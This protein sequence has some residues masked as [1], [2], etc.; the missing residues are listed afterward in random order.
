[1]VSLLLNYLIATNIR[2][3]KEKKEEVEEMIQKKDKKDK[4][5]LDSR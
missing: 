3:K 5:L 4:E 1:M 2:G